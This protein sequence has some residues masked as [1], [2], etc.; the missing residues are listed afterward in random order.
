MAGKGVEMRAHQTL[1]SSFHCIGI[2]GQGIF[3]IL[4]EYVTQD[5]FLKM[6]LE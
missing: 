3:K 2:V 6:L 4:T 5:H 1:R